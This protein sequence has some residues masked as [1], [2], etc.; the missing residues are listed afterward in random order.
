M[1]KVSRIETMG[2]TE[3][4]LIYMRVDIIKENPLNSYIYTD[5]Y[6]LTLYLK[7]FF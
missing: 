1:K 7:K 5:I 2:G 3:L 4:K 6:V